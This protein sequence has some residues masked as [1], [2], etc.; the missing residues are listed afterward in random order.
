MLASVYKSAGSPKQVRGISTNVA[1][2]NAWIQIPGEFADASDAQYNKAQDEQRYITMIGEKLS[3]NGM[4]NHA[5]VD[6]GRNGVT[7][8]LP[9]HTS[10]PISHFSDSS[11]NPP[12]HP[13]L[14]L[15]STFFTFPAFRVA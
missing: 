6:T 2:W 4:P 9:I 11:F 7:G 8:M 13:H 1:G 3:A 15:F 14:P 12:F 10:P 5:I